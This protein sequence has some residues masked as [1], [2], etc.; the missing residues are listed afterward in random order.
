MA[1]KADL[2]LHP[3]RMQIIQRLAK[4]KANVQELMD[5]LTDIPQ[6]T[7]YRH[8]KTL[9]DHGIL[10]IVEEKK[11]RGTLERTYSL[12]E[13]DAAHINAEEASNWDKDEHMQMFMTYMAGLINK[14]E[15]YLDG[16]TDMHQ[17]VFG[18]S[19]V[20][21]HL[22]PEQ[23]QEF[24]QDLQHIFGKYTS[25]QPTDETKSATM[26]QLFIPEQKS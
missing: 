5:A 2:I 22:T 24:T 4:G 16:P 20:D 11:I 14:T 10:H 19:Q 3:V 7:L 25:Q 23:W 12:K 21:L 8:L 17:D 6:A 15:R 9:T 18:Y 13:H 1:S 26:A